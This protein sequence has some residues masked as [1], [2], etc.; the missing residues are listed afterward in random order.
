MLLEELSGTTTGNYVLGSPIPAS[1][2][3]SKLTERYDVYLPAST[4]HS[5]LTERYDM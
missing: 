2:V 4:V 5:K 1:I 3:L